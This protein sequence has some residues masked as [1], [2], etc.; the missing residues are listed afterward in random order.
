MAGLREGTASEGGPALAASMEAAGEGSTAE[1]GATE[2]AAVGDSSYPG[3]R[4]SE[5]RQSPGD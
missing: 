2:A 1:V 4:T 5:R 3:A